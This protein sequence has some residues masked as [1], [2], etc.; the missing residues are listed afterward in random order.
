[1]I[2][3]A[4]DSKEDIED[5][6]SYEYERTTQIKWYDQLLL[7]RPLKVILALLLLAVVCPILIYRYTFFTSIDLPPSDGFSVGSCLAPR[8]QRLLCGHGEVPA[9]ECHPQCCYDLANNLCFHRFPSRFS[10]IMDQNW[11]ERV[12]L[13]P[14]VAAVPYGFQ[15]SVTNIRLSIDEIS[16]THLSISFYNA[17]KLSLTGR[18]IKDKKYQYEVASPELS[19]SVNS[20]E[21]TIFNTLR[22]PLIASENIWELTF[23]ITEE[24][25]YGLGDLPLKEHTVKV[26]YNHDGGLSSIPLIFARLNGTYHGLLI[27]ILEPTEVRINA[28]KQI[29]VRSITRQGLKFHLFTGPKPADIMKDVINLI[30]SFNKLEY[31]MLGTHICSEIS[32]TLDLART[33]LTTFLDTASSQSMPFESHCGV[34]PILFDNFCGPKHDLSIIN[35]AAQFLKSSRKRFVPHVHPYIRYMDHSEEILEANETTTQTTLLSTL[36]DHSV[37]HDTLEHYRHILIRKPNSDDYYKGL[38]NGTEVV[39]PDYRNVNEEF[40]GVLWKIDKSIDGLFLENNWPLDESEKMLNITSNYLPYFNEH[41]K[42]AFRNTPLW[43]TTLPD[44]EKY[45]YSHNN[46]GNHFVSAME[47]IN[48]KVPT[49]SSNQRMNGAILI[50]RQNIHTSWN[51]LQRELT[52]AALGGISG[53]WLWS[54]PICGDTENFDSETQNN[55]CAKWYMAGTYLPMIKIH[56]KNYRRDPLFFTGTDRNRMINALKIRAS[57]LP[58]FFTVLQEGPLLRPMF[59]QFPDTEPLQ[60]LTTQFSVGDHLLIVPNLH[61]SQS[62]V[63]VRL[64]PGI[65]YE[66]WSGLKLEGEE[67]EAVTMTTTEADFLTLVKGGSIISMQKDVRLTADETRQQSSYSLTIALACETSTIA[68]NTTINSNTSSINSNTSS[69]ECE[70]SGKLFITNDMIIDFKADNGSIIIT[71]IG[72]DFRVL[73]DESKA[74]SAKLVNELNIFGLQDSVNNYDNH[75]NVKTDLDLCQLEI[76]KEI[77]FY[78]LV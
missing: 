20:G 11:D 6:L 19:V 5:N 36:T 26:I 28:D 10:Y 43:N 57:F 38:I 12:L 37:C 7:N 50:N 49:W 3:H 27:D 60:D 24:I 25:M 55:L 58:Y 47:A 41:F 72:D 66:F 21:T 52:A 9:S 67:G 76:E 1:M 23:R 77:L 13:Q 73:C 61:P 15:N 65:W 71:A 39:Y 42:T 54:S 51:N 68:D 63:H 17:A 56:S 16:S 18:R 45:L 46:Y 69:I 30:G 53:H 78:Y 2:P 33:N 70:A 4:N 34:T 75:R 29:V 62:H 59:Y 22:G 74:V 14:R 32:E 35:E 31:W 48:G 8:N 40:I 64:P 44:G